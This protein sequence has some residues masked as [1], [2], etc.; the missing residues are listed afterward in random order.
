AQALPFTHGERL[1][2]SARVGSVG[3]GTAVMWIEGP[4]AVRGRSAFHLR[5]DVHAK[6]G[7]VKVVNVSQSWL[8]PMRMTSLRFHK[9]ERHPLS[10]REQQADIFPDEQRWT[11]ADGQSGRTMSE[12][13][14]DELSFIYFLRTAQLQ[15]GGALRFDRHFEASRNPTLV[16]VLGQ[17]TLATRAGTF[18]TTVVEMQVR[19]GR[20]GGGGT[21]RLNFSN[22]AR[23][24]PVR[25][26]SSIPVAGKVVLTLETYTAGSAGVVALR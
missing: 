22:D 7:F 1:T 4:V 23:R 8:D 3:R 15:A 11:S 16:K 26:E 12:Q 17:E 21:I 10:K 6:V 9:T 18:E 14:L 20:Y 5:F 13:P 19:D 24:L 2:Y 25:I